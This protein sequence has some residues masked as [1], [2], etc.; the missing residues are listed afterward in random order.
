MTKACLSALALLRFAQTSS[1][2][3]YKPWFGP[4]LVPE[5]EVDLAVQA[6]HDVDTEVWGHALH[7]RRRFSRFGN[8][9][10]PH[11]SLIGRTRSCSGRYAQKD[12]WL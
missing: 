7:I 4:E 1:A 5:A 2:T 10:I 3:Q 12:F 9:Y 11:T 6:F 8:A